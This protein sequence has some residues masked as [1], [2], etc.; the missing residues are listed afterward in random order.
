M[1]VCALLLLSP[2]FSVCSYAACL[3]SALEGVLSSLC[4]FLTVYIT[5][6][7]WPSHVLVSPCWKEHA[8]REH[9]V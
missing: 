9:L 4:A 5:L 6:K 3:P 1:S 8:W 7:I 2:L